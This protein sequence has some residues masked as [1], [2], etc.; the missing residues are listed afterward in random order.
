[1]VELE[2]VTREKLHRNKKV[3][4]LKTGEHCALTVHAPHLWNN[5]SQDVKVKTNISS[6]KKSL[7][8]LLFR[9]AC[10]YEDEHMS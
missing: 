7:K 4:N 2:Q 1:M 8:T 6:F 10:N 9:R 5:L 3:G